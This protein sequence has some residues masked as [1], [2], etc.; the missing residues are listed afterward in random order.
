[1]THGGGGGSKIGQKSVTY[2][3]NGPLLQKNHF[4][5]VK[6]G[7]PIYAIIPNR[8]FM[9]AEKSLKGKRDDWLVTATC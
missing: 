8:D 4:K 9:E 5:N 7:N 3:L 6:G 1:M 2:Y